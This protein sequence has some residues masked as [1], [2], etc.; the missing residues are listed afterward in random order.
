MSAAI[1]G[2]ISIKLMKVDPGVLGRYMANDPKVKA[3]I[4]AVANA[5]ADRAQANLMMVGNPGS[6]VIYPRYLGHRW[7][8]KPSAVA[9]GV[10]VKDSSQVFPLQA[11][12]VEPAEVTRVALVVADHPYSWPYEFGGMGIR[13]SGFMR[14]AVRWVRSTTPGTVLRGYRRPAGAP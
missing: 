7:S 9:K 11:A 4:N 3:K 5:V 2:S 8:A 10:K 14:Q 6:K 1:K 12:R 13:S